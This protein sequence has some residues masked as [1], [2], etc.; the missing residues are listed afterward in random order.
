MTATAAKS[1]HVD[2]GAGDSASLEQQIEARIAE[3]RAQA[4]P[5]QPTSAMLAIC[6]SVAKDQVVTLDRDPVLE[7]GLHAAASGAVDNTAAY[8]THEFWG[9]L[10]GVA[11]R[12][13]VRIT[14]ATQRT[15]RRI[16]R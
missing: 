3:F 14:P 2:E 15:R 11:W 16:E 1:E 8:G 13:H 12:V 4:V 10:G 7:A 9:W 6:E 5:N